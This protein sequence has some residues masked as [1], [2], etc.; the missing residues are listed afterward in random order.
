MLKKLLIT[1]AVTFIFGGI[2]TVS[3]ETGERI[4]FAKGKSSTVIK[5]VTGRDGVTYIIRAKSGQNLVFNLKPTS[6]VGIKV[7]TD[8]KYGHAVLLREERG[9]TYG[10]GLDE[11][12]DYTIF[13]GSTNHKSIPFTLT[14]K[15]TKLT[16]I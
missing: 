4:Q 8:G 15:T 9:G 11:T 13:I 7:E 10:V 16:D 6:N 2:H 14:V 5:G 12:G 3:A 1:F